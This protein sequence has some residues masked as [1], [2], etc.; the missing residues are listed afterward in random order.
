MY[1]FNMLCLSIFNFFFDVRLVISISSLVLVVIEQQIISI[2]L[3]FNFSGF[4][5]PCRFTCVT[6]TLLVILNLFIYTRKKS[7]SHTH[8]MS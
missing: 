4:S 6:I 1:Y 2:T 8:E 5:V 7:F 3:N